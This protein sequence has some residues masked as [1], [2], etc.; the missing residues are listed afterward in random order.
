MQCDVDLTTPQHDA[1]SAHD[2][3][4][5]RQLDTTLRCDDTPIRR[6]YATTSYNGQ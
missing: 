6:R 1:A 5:R 4:L 2:A 3:L